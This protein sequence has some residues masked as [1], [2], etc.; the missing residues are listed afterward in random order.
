MNEN[1]KAL[2]ILRIAI[3][4]EIEGHKFY[5][6]IADRI[7]DKEVRYLCKNLARD[8]EV[9]RRMLEVRY[10]HLSEGKIFQPGEDIDIENI[11]NIADMGK[12]ELLEIA[13]G[14]ERKGL[15]YY[16]SNAKV[17]SDRKSKEILLDLVDFEKEHEMKLLK[18][19]EENSG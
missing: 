7:D 12:A 14:L 19:L 15:E 3:R 16:S 9:H 1:Q 6:F 2:E 13:L 11:S 5:Q 18:I 8:E 10:N 17:V 4:M